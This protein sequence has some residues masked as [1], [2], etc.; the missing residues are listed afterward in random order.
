M[1]ELTEKQA[2]LVEKLVIHGPNY[3]VI[4]EE[5]GLT[6]GNIRERAKHPVVKEEVLRIARDN[7]AFAAASAAQGMI[8]LQYADNDTEQGALRLKANESILNRVGI[9]NH[10]S[11]E[12]KADTD[13]G[14]FILPAKVLVPKQDNDTENTEDIT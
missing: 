3:K 8:D 5:L 10:T 2:I 4:A 14:I 6:V 7:L 9:T 12:V 11:V 13:N 1:S